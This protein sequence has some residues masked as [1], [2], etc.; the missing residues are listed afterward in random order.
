MFVLALINLTSD[1]QL[2]GAYVSRTKTNNL[3]N[4]NFQDK[5]K[6]KDILPHKNYVKDLF[7]DCANGLKSN[8]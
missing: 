4:L 1:L 5:I 3:L 6:I 7:S 2:V 8:I